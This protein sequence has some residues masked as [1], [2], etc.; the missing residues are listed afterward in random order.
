MRRS[1][2][3]KTWEVFVPEPRRAVVEARVLGLAASR[4]LHAVRCALA[5]E[6]LGAQQYGGADLAADVGHAVQ[7]KAGIGRRRRGRAG[8]A[9]LV[10]DFERMA[11]LRQQVGIA[12]P[13]R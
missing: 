9:G 11:L 7:A 1:F 6:R 5:Q 12:G 4:Q 3:E 2:Q 10:A 13:G 8:G